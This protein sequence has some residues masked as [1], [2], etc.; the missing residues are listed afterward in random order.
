MMRR[1]LLLLTLFAGCK[2]PSQ[3]PP[4]LGFPSLPE[5]IAPAPSSNSGIPEPNWSSDLT[6]LP[7][8]TGDSLRVTPPA[9]PFDGSVKLN[10]PE[11]IAPGQELPVRIDWRAE[12]P[13]TV[14][15][16]VPDG[17]QLMRSEPPA[18]L[19]GRNLEWNVPIGVGTVVVTYQPA[20]VGRIDLE[21]EITDGFAEPIATRATTMIGVVQMRLKVHSPRTA[22]IGEAVNLE[23]RVTNG[24]QV[25]AQRAVLRADLDSGLEHA[26]GSRRVDMPVGPIGPGETRTMIVPV[27]VRRSGSLAAT[28]SIQGETGAA[29]NESLHI[30]VREARLAVS[31]DGPARA[32]VN[33]S[34]TWSVRVI[35]MGDAP[36]NN[37]TARVQ[38]PPELRLDPK[39]KAAWTIGTL[40]PR[41]E[42]TLPVSATAIAPVTRTSI[43][44]S[45]IGERIPEARSDVTLEAIGV[46]LL[47]L[48]LRGG[49]SIVE[50]GKNVIYTIEVKNA[51]TLPLANLDITT[52]FPQLL[53]AKYGI[54][55]TMVS[56]NSQ[57]VTF[58]RISQL[59]PNQTIIYRLE[60]EAMQPGDARITVEARSDS[61][62]TPVRQ[63]EATRIVTK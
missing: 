8:R 25:T 58:A 41:E 47:K 53:T 14:R 9:R 62:P 51:G 45:A 37:V 13:T 6:T 55:P 18:R 20:R 4:A 57:R 32:M 5:N 36:A 3:Q 23:A 60:A 48:S 15:H 31:L 33:Q 44:A 27:V 52:E 7:V 28:L 56:I 50:V 11:G 34:A 22:T 39:A 38:L 16:P 17:V 2:T 29:V 42:Q 21:A 40:R 61:V 59:E 26:S 63:D 24:G 54:G 19:V 46:P 12:A 30:D 43:V 35:N 1:W 10:A 49:D